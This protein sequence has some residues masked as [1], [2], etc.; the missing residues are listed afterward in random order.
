MMVQEA[1]HASFRGAGSRGAFRVII[2]PVKPPPVTVPPKPVLF[3]RQPC[4]VCTAY[5]EDWLRVVMLS[6]SGSLDATKIQAKRLHRILEPFA[7]ELARFFARL[8]STEAYC[9][10]QYLATKN[11]SKGQAGGGLCVPV[12]E[13][14]TAIARFCCHSQLSEFHMLFQDS[15]VSRY[16]EYIDSFVSE[17]ILQLW[18]SVPQIHKEHT[19]VCQPTQTGPALGLRSHLP[20]ARAAVAAQKPQRSVASRE[21]LSDRMRDFDAFEDVDIDDLYR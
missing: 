14:T 12:S 8:Q 5:I 1:T 2:H 11:V 21:P 9:V 4:H 13:M 10:Q 15:G 7:V 6:E 18:E 16:T 17:V 19:K 3:S 20:V